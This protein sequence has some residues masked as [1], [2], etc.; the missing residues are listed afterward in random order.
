MTSPSPE[1]LPQVYVKMTWSFI[2]ASIRKIYAS[3][4]FDH[5]ITFLLVLI[6]MYMD[7]SWVK[8]FK[9]ISRS[10]SS[11]TLLAKVIAKQIARILE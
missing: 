9:Q 10:N 4:N 8:N 7:T 6:P 11:Y 3:D 5:R 2:K 1:W